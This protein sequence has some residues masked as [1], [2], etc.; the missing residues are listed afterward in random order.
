ML[1]IGSD[2]HTRRVAG[3]YG[4]RCPGRVAKPSCDVSGQ[5]SHPVG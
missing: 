3:A 4:R 5:K 2:F 1:M